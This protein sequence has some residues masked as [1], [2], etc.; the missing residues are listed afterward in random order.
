MSEKLTLKGMRDYLP[1]E[2]M[3][4]EMVV[5]TITKVF[6]LYGYRPLETPAIEYM[7]TLKAKSGD[8]IAG[9]IFKLE[10]EEA[11]LRFDLTVPLARVAA[12]NALP[13]PFKRYCISKVWRKEEPQKGRMREFW[14]ADVD[15]VGSKSMRSEAELIKVA[16]DALMA[17]GFKKPLFLLNN[18]KILDALAAKLGFADEKETVFRLL[19]KMDK[20]GIERVRADLG[21]ILGKKN[22]DGL[23]S[24]LA[25]EGSN[26]EKLGKAG[27]ISPEGAKEL[28]EIVEN[29][30]GL[31]VKVDFF[32]VRGLGYY[33][34]P[35]F[36]VKLSDDIGSVGGGGRYD[37]LLGLYGQ[38]DCATGISL[39]IERL[40]YLLKDKAGEKNGKTYTRI[41]VASVKGCCG[42]AEEVA[43]MFRKAGVETETDLNERALG[44]QFD[45]AN[46]LG[47]KYVAVVG[48]KEKQAKKIT[49]RDMESGAEEMM[50]VGKA[51]EKVLD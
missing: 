34:G 51:M 28:R 44:K 3:L 21:G 39:G 47:I 23:F 17:L 5:D 12:N 38:G 1:E 6:R 32:L 4:R 29:C 48:E 13:K 43:Q 25:I 31:E 10:G 36:E 50:D 7:S 9:Q 49:L 24:V 35:V 27:E 42:Y 37:N 14:Q 20:I 26:E 15:V 8:E 41:F 18:R 40:L 11:G 30:P 45:Y 46:S 19:D 16:N 2:M 33:T 22:C